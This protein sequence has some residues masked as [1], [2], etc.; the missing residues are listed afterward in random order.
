MEYF[1]LKI[2]EEFRQKKKIG[3]I[4]ANISIEISEGISGEIPERIPVT[5]PEWTPVGVSV[6]FLD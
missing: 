6:E 3:G 4:S 1:L 2:F 5:I